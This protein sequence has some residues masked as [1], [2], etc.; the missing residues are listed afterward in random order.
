MRHSNEISAYSP[1]PHGAYILMED[2]DI[3]HKM[4]NLLFTPIC[5]EWYSGRVWG[6]VKL[7]NHTGASDKFRRTLVLKDIT[8][9]IWQS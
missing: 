4:H 7:Y 5:G 8:R 3:D 2:T 1:C 9:D 6:S